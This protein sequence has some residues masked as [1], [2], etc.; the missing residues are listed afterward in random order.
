M[1]KIDDLPAGVSP[2]TG[3]DLDVVAGSGISAGMKPGSGYLCTALNDDGT[4]D[5]KMT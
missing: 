4:T 1:L 5:C 3:D 2:L